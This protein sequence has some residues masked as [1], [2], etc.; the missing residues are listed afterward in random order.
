MHRKG[1]KASA[2]DKFKTFMG[3]SPAKQIKPKASKPSRKK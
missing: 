3:K 1:K 2:N